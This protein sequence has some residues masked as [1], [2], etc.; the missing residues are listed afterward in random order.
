MEMQFEEQK[1]KLADGI[2]E[3]YEEKLK[4]QKIKFSKMSKERMKEFSE[5]INQKENIIKDLNQN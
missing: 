2:L 3:E 5:I 4:M 1:L